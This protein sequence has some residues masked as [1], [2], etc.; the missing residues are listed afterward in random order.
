MSGGEAP[1]PERADRRWRWLAAAAGALFAILAGHAAWVET[2]TVDE[3][4]HVPAGAARLARGSLTLYAKTPPL[5]QSL[6]ALPVVLDPSVRVP[7][8]ERRAQ[9]W[10]PWSYGYAF[11]QENREAYLGIFFRARCVSVLLTCLAGWLLFRWARDIFGGRAASVATAAFFLDPTILA[12][13]HLATVDAGAMLA[14]LASLAALRWACARPSRARAAAAGAV[15][16][17]ALLSKYT[18]ILLLPVLAILI[19]YHRRERPGRGAAELALL[20]LA[21]LATVNAGMGFR[22]SF[23]PA[24]SFRPESSLGRTVQKSLPAG[25][26][27]PLPRDYVVGFD[28]VK[29]DTERGEFGSYLLGE[30][31]ARGWWYSDLVA[32]AAKTPIPILALLAA[33]PFFLWRARLAPAPLLELLVPAGVLLAA[34]VFLNKLD[35]GLRYLLPVYPLLYLSTAS[36]WGGLRGRASRWLPA[37]ILASAAATAVWAHP[38]YVSYFNVAAGGAA[39]G[40]RILIDSNLDWGQDLYRLKPAL[41]RLGVEGEIGLLYYGHVDPVLYG[42]RYALVPSWEIRNVVAVSVN[43]LMGH[44]YPATSADG[45]AVPIGRDHLAW[46][47][48]REPVARAGTIW[49]FD[50]RARREG[51]APEAA[52]P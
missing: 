38:S 42:I 19:A 6:L 10:G 49:I 27:I 26:P 48:G 16:G 21:A 47:R 9:A 1:P 2:P 44:T 31:S 41:E 22:G 37:G 36:V 32:F 18:A 15:W 8:P 52:P 28:A 25:L 43:Y 24:V 12:H 4:A 11:M 30:W 14:I 45:R 51:P 35:I 17:A 40:H 29:R 13:G 20:I 23:A 5:V 33:A 3:F 46:L 34:M 39:N 7:D 50:T